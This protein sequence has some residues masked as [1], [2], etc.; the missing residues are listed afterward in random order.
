MLHAFNLA[1][2]VLG[3]P[4]RYH[5]MTSSIGFSPGSWRRIR[6]PLQSF[7]CYYCLVEHREFFSKT[8]RVLAIE[9]A[10]PIEFNAHAQ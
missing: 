7:S 6:Y 10:R 5:H 3:C 2:A 4:V 8:Q 1:A 9:I